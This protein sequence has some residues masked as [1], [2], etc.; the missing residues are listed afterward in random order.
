[1]NNTF[2]SNKDD[3]MTDC[4]EFDEFGQTLLNNLSF[5]IEGIL[6]TLIAIV[7]VL[8]NFVACL[9]LVSISSTFLCAAFTP[10]YPKSTKRRSSYQCNFALLGS[11]HTKPARKILVKLTPSQHFTS[12]FFVW[13]CFALLFSSYRLA[14]FV[15]LAKAVCKMLVKLT[16]GL[17]SFIHD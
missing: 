14:L 10:T 11:A 9:V 7:G 16:K 13:K 4:P 17:N 6:Q 2:E 12:S 5:Y 1:M 3:V 8:G 15:F